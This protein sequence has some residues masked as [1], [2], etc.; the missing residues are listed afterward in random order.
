MLP[1]FRQ[2]SEV[3]HRLADADLKDLSALGDLKRVQD[4]E[5][6]CFE[7]AADPVLAAVPGD[8]H[9]NLEAAA[10]LLNQDNDHPKDHETGHLTR[11]GSRKLAGV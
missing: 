3:F 7:Y 2:A 5:A 4:D 8:R 1:L 9:R 6:F 10:H 11:N